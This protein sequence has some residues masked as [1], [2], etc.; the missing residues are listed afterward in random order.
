MAT[1]FNISTIFSAVNHLSQPMHAMT[2]QMSEF[3]RAATAGTA[4][5]NRSM[6]STGRAAGTLHRDIARINDIRFDG[7]M[8]RI[9]GITRSMGRVAQGFQNAGNAALGIGAAGIA[10]GYAL[11]RTLEPVR[12]SQR[13]ANQL[14]VVYGQGKSVQDQAA[15][16][17]QQ[18]KATAELANKLPGAVADIADFRA[19]TK[20]YGVEGNYELIKGFTD[21]LGVMGKATLDNEVLSSLQSIMIGNQSDLFEK[22]GLKAFT[23]KKTH[24]I[25]IRDLATKQE[26]FFKSDAER[27]QFLSKFL[28]TKYKGGTELAMGSLTGRESNLGDALNAATVDIWNN[29]GALDLYNQKIMEFTKAI[30]ELTPKVTEMLKPFVAWLKNNN[31]LIN[32]MVIAIPVMLG[33]GVALKAIGFAISGL[34]LPIRALSMAFTGLRAAMAFASGLSVV[35]TAAAALASVPLLTLGAI[36]AAVVAVG[37]AIYYVVK[38]WDELVQGFKDV[39]AKISADFAAWK[40]P[41]LDFSGI[42]KPLQD[43]FSQALNWITTTW[44]AFGLPTLDF[45]GIWDGLLNGFVKVINV[46]KSIWASLPS[47]TA[48]TVPSA[49]PA[50][51]SNVIPMGPYA[52]QKAEAGSAGVYAKQDASKNP[53]SIYSKPD[54]LKGSAP[55]VNLHQS[56]HNK[57]TANGIQTVTKTSSPGLNIKLNSGVNKRGVVAQ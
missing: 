37:A 16:G 29:T 26:F 3:N 38:N 49:K 24:E 55:V 4:G 54:Y 9:H 33:A 42:W 50:G 44:Q 8:S 48:P 10:G 31:E 12:E 41:K 47:M 53:A 45:S 11:N 43:L 2:R 21:A 14:G 39:K 25:G 56:I 6:A 46:I 22:T 13:A 57:S 40:L 28:S 52:K 27:I 23:D 5:I 34:I 15:I 32:K 20:R 51:Q 1:P 7:L 18:Y 30:T 19:M 36:A 17:M 35:S